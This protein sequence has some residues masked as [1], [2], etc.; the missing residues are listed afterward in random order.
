MRL[1][2]LLSV[3]AAAMVLSVAANAA[4][5]AEL[6]NNGPAV[7]GGTSIL[8]TPSTTLGFG[9]QT[10][11]GNSVA[12][13]FSFSGS[14]W[15]VSSLDFFSYQTAAVGF[16]FTSATWS[17]IS[18]TNINTGTV[19]ASGTTAVTN[20]GL[21][22]YRVTS[23]TLTDT[24]RAI[25]KVSVDVTDFSLTAGNY[26]ITWSLAG[27]G[28][29]GPWAPPVAGSTSGNALQSLA[30]APYATVVDAG[31]GLNYELPFIINGTVAASA[32]PE[33]ATWAMMIG[34]FG[35]IGGAMRSRRRKTTVS[36]A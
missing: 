2:K 29:S 32:V 18:G 12:D 4:Q 6:V 27:T 9:A 1:S 34:G 21:A 36:F 5:A 23:T 31:S 19:V 16:T 33:P 11:A 26:F 20:G 7:I 10:T 8:V 3:S 25:Y 30:G 15:N 13:N 17:I 24:S 35:M 22:G 28:A 14:N